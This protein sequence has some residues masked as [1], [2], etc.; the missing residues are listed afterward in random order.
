[1]HKLKLE[2]M[3]KSND[4]AVLILAVGISSRLGTPKQ[5]LTYKNESLIKIAVR[6][7]NEKYL[8]KSEE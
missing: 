8:V 1:M 6:K 4:L 7:A 5:L 3:K 2:E